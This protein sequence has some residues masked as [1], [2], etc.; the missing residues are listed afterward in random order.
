MD[1]RARSSDCD[2]LFVKPLN[3]HYCRGGIAWH[4]THLIDD[5]LRIAE[6]DVKG[7]GAKAPASDVAKVLGAMLCHKDFIRDL[8]SECAK[9]CGDKLRIEENKEGGKEADAKA[10]RERT[11]CLDVMFTGLTRDHFHKYAQMKGVTDITQQSIQEHAQAVL[12]QPQQLDEKL[13]EPDLGDQSIYEQTPGPVVVVPSPTTQRRATV[14][15][16]AEATEEVADRRTSTLEQASADWQ[17][18]GSRVQT[19]RTQAHPQTARDTA[20]AGANAGRREHWGV[21]D[22]EQLTAPRP[23]VARRN[24]S[25]AGFWD[26][27]YEQPQGRPDMRRVK[28]APAG[29]RTAPEQRTI[30]RAPVRLQTN[31]NDAPKAFD[32]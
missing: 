5:E 19:A 18:V 21:F 6:G 28:S 9:Q 20:D 7:A 11:E 31:A 32:A 23:P 27:P 14:Q 17:R 16:H 4:T 25:P 8:Q 15:T 12:A 10:E 30:R 3:D 1:S 26:G 24:S 29:E 22:V 13:G 2:N